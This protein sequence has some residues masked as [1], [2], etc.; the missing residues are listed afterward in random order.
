MIQELGVI[1]NP[2]AVRAQD[3]YL[4]C[5]LMA[6]GQLP[7]YVPDA[8][9]THCVRLSFPMY[10]YKAV[11]IA[12]AENRTYT[13]IERRGIH[14]QC[15]DA[16]RLQVLSALFKSAGHNSFGYDA[17]AVV[18]VRKA[19]RKLGRAASRWAVG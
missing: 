15:T 3:T 10:L 14:F 5:E 16:E 9:V 17:L 4:L 18:L 7:M 11:A 13:A 8:I 2:K 1:F 19:L 6:R 12:S